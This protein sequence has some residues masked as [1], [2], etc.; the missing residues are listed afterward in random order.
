MSDGRERPLTSP[1]QGAADG[2]PTPAEGHSEGSERYGA[3]LIE[4]RTK[5]D[6]RTLI[7]FSDAGEPG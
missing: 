5:D 3:L 4:R 7:F 6:G 1:S 2:Q